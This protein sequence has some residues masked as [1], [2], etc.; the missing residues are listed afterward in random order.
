MVHPNEIKWISHSS[1]KTDKIDARKLAELGRGGLL[2]KAVHIVEG[3]VR[4]LRE[5]LSAREKLMRKRVDL[6]NSIQG[7]MKQEGV[8][9]PKGFFSVANYEELVNKLKVA[10]TQKLIVKSMMSAIS[11]LKL[12]EDKLLVKIYAIEDPRIELL[13]SVPRIGKLSSRVLLSALDEAGRFNNKKSV[14]KYGALTPRIYQSG[15]NTH[16]GRINS[17][18]RRELRR[19]L[20]QCAHTVA[21]MSKNHAAKPLYDFFKRIEKKR[22][23][24]IAVVALA[25]KLLT[26]TY[27]VLKL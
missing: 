11:S 4:E 14:A 2:P 13:E 3:H 25:R 6:V 8:K 9:I 23:K 18:G 15:N 22:N 20:L 7:I 19:V 10:D 17:D 1:G 27:G 5:L 26:T 24:K 16:M 21:R 12:S